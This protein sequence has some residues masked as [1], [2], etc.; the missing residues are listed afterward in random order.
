MTTH[1]THESLF[2]RLYQSKLEQLDKALASDN[3][4]RQLVLQAEAEAISQELRQ[5][6][7]RAS[8]STA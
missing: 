7:A 6:A 5:M 4:L 1:S 2:G 8:V 3:T